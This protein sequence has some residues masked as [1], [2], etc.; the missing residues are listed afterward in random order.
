M[1]TI[2]MRKAAVTAALRYVH[3]H[4]DDNADLDDINQAFTDF[5]GRQPDTDDDPWSDLCAAIDDGDTADDHAD[6]WRI[7]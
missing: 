4:D 1:K 6:M 7:G 5:F 3:T 2:T